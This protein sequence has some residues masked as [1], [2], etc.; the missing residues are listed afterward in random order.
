MNAAFGDHLEH[1]RRGGDRHS[2]AR[3]PFD[4]SQIQM[5]GVIRAVSADVEAVAP[6]FAVSDR[7]GAPFAH[8]VII[9]K[10]EGR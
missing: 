2:A 4:V 7:H 1:R 10:K 6:A 3:M 9:A 5:R 8:S